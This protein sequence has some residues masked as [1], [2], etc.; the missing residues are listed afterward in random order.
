MSAGIL[1]SITANLLNY[2]ISLLYINLLLLPTISIISI[3][4]MMLI[5]HFMIFTLYE[6]KKK[7]LIR[8]SSS[9]NQKHIFTA[10]L[11]SHMIGV[12]ILVCEG[13]GGEAVV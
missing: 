11:R 2:F 3:I 12:R 4:E 10:I 6:L 5:L 7:L 1:F 13:G 8:I 9:F